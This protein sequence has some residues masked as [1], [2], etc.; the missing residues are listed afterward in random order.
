MTTE[1]VSPTPT[2]EVVPPSAEPER[3]A[4]VVPAEVAPESVAEAPEHPTPIA[5]EP[6][7]TPQPLAA[8]PLTADDSPTE[9]APKK[10][11]KPKAAVASAAEAVVEDAAPTPEP[12][13]AAPVAPEA[14][15]KK[16]W[17]VVKV[18]SGQ[19]DSI[20]ARLERNIKIEGLE[21]F[22]SQ[23]VIPVERVTEIKKT[24]K[25]NEDGEKVTKEKRVIKE[26]KKY[27]GYLMAEVEFNDQVQYLFRETPGVGDFVGGGPN[28]PP[29]P[30]TDY[31]V[32][33]MLGNEV[34]AKD[35]PNMKG[36][37]KKIKVKID[38]ERGDKVRL[39]DGAFAGTEGEVLE[40]AEA[41]DESETPKITVKVQFWGR[42]V[43]I[44]NLEFWQVDKV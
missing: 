43:K 16:K 8:V 4:D 3:T 28:K 27:P 32:Q 1:D 44:D 38:L 22:I 36:S 5:D 12:T 33:R 2:A 9:H 25:K 40:I 13:S 10:V 41:K 14:E 30:M 17:Y 18:A 29:A 11:K 42:D 19:E 37:P 24:T 20:K 31:E 26:K 34:S 39:R 7:P 23:I 15:N 35:A 21:P 6:A